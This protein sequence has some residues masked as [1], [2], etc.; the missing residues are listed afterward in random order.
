MT[1]NTL[2]LVDG[3]YYLFRA[4]H[5]MGRNFNN[6]RGEPTGAIY[7]VLNMVRKLLTD[8][9]PDFFAVVFDAHGK[10]FR[11]DIYPRYKANRPPAPED[12]ICQIT[13]LHEILRAQG[14]PLI[15]IDG[16]EADDV[17]ATLATQAEAEGMQ[18]IISTGDKDL[19]QIVNQHIRLVNTM[20]DSLL[21]PEGV[22]KKYG[23][24][25]ERIIDYL[26]L[27]GDTSDNVPGVP[28]VG[29]KTAVKW[30]E[31]YG[32]LDEIIRHADEIGG[33]AGEN[34]R[35]SIPALPLSRNLITLKT[36]VELEL[37]PRK[38]VCNAPDAKMLLEHYKRWEFRGW[39]S[40]LEQDAGADIP[41]TAVPDT[42]AIDYATVITEADLDQW[43]ARLE[44]AALIALDT[45]TTSLDYMQA[46]L[47]GISIC[48]EPGHAAYIPV[49]HNYPGVPQQLP[50]DV[51]L[52]RLKPLLE[53]P[54]LHKV[55]H[56][57]KY[58]AHI[59]AN[60]GI[61]LAGIEH[62]TMLQSYVLNSVSTRHDMD[63]LALKY[64]EVKTTHYEDVAGKG[65]KQ[66]SFAQVHL[67][68]ASHYAA[69]DA[70]ITLQL[71]DRLWPVLAADEG[72]KKLY[73]TIE[74]PLISVLTRME[75][76]GVLIDT[77][78]L[79]Q[80]SIELGKQMQQLEQQA[81]EL[82]GAS[83]NI[84]SPKQIQEILFERM[85]IPVLAKT[86]GGQ[87]STAEPVLQELAEEYELPRIILA[88]RGLSK[89][90]S[91]YTERLP[92]QVNLETGRIHASFHQAVAATGRLSSSDPN[93]QNIPVRTAEGRK[94]RQ[95]FIPQPGYKLLAADYSQIELRI[96]AHLSG[97]N[98]LLEAFTRQEDIH[99]AT[100]A[101]IFNVSIEQV[102]N[103]QRR[104]AKAIN[105]GLIYGMSAFGLAKQLGTD[106]ATASAYIDRYFSRYTAVREYM[107]KIRIT[108][109]KT[110]YVE[111]VFH[112]RLYLPEIN[113]RNAARRQYAERT[114]INAPMQGTAADIIKKAMIDIDTG[115]C[116]G[117]D[118]IRMIMQVHDEL[119]FEIRDNIT[120]N[121]SLEI[122][123]R[124]EK[125]AG[126]SV[127]LLVDIGTGDNWDEAH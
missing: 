8:Y 16:V 39:I 99:K 79:Q 26:T 92:Q 86:P 1:P 13:P 60:H 21:D 107:D 29:P 112:R 51:V 75:R 70:D 20:S 106:R 124:M 127:P 27:I 47:V 58:D 122:R 88:H 83:F 45:E 10:S 82:A 12:L 63:S 33:K 54:A 14:M 80:Q 102:S 103:E 4:Y 78:M 28:M 94:I 44:G 89:L 24:P 81:H 125:A 46:R 15:I 84:G 2:V 98:S 116:R 62:D 18:T 115:L 91:T 111:T 117:R 50:R 74:R 114:A 120:D 100:A 85:Q 123:Q 52:E 118:D 113:S 43:C 121:A 67:D 76:N 41:E 101:E 55:G 7:G 3:S 38:L 119:V 23:V 96:M 90:R 68:S 95:A 11:H 109:R 104:A 19:A 69:E 71:H 25:P 72:L 97:D 126:L 77:G 108:A 36:D 66:I 56:N 53:S 105:F 32:S 73:L 87:P 49:A 37:S 40:R 42:P 65:A 93:L 34:L 5:A 110:G 31:Q 57:L 64:L 17:I 59:L 35:A 22:R 30:L 61:R 48:T 9:T 6:S